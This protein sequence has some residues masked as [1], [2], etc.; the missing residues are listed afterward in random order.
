MSDKKKDKKP[1]LESKEEPVINYGNPP[2]RLTTE[3]SEILEKAREKAKKGLPLFSRDSDEEMIPNEGELDTSD[4]VSDR[5][6]ELE[7][8][9]QFK[10]DSY[11]KLFAKYQELSK[12]FTEL[13]TAYKTLQE[14]PKVEVAPATNPEL[15]SIKSSISAMYNEFTNEAAGRNRDRQPRDIIF[16]TGDFGL[17][18][19]FRKAF[20]FLK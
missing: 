20:S 5:I 8:E 1:K 16:L 9:L 7:S 13:Q 17:I 2:S 4:N 12:N 15:D 11:N 6:F 18:N 10:T 3:Q 19:K 14:Q